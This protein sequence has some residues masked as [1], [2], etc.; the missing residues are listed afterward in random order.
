ME[1]N[2]KSIEV[3]VLGTGIFCNM[4]SSLFD[5]TKKIPFLN[6]IIFPL[7]IILDKI[8]SIFDK[9]LRNINPLGYFFIIKKN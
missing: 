4:Y 9:N 5:K 6:I 1:N 7:A 8:L 2:F 3:K